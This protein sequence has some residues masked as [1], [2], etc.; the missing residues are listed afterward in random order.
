MSDRVRESG[1]DGPAVTWRVALSFSPEDERLV[2][3]TSA[4]DLCFGRS[5]RGLK[6]PSSGLPATALK[7][8]FKEN[9]QLR[10]HSAG[11][12]LCRRCV[13]LPFVRA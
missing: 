8:P 3:K 4:E 10:I 2:L 11:S 12:K 1:P 7:L 13:A 5:E 6:D 9:G